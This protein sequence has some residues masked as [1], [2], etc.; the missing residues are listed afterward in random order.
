VALALAAASLLGLPAGAVAEAAGTEDAER[1]CSDRG[2]TGQA[3]DECVAEETAAQ[4]QNALPEEVRRSQ[5]GGSGSDGGQT[6][7]QTQSGDGIQQN[8]QQSDPSGSIVQNAFINGHRQGRRARRCED[9][10]LRQAQRR[11]RCASRLRKMPKTIATPPVPPV[12]AS[13]IG[14]GVTLSIVS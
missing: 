2:L 13:E 8:E 7:N 3:F 14:V 10:T 4:Q 1:T 12:D 9:L 5:D 11:P 6:L